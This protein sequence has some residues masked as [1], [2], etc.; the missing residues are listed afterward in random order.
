MRNVAWSRLDSIF[1]P[2]EAVVTVGAIV[3]VE[4]VIKDMQISWISL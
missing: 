3:V 4:A 1:N 2:L